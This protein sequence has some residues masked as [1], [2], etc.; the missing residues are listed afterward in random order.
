MTVLFRP[1]GNLSVAPTPRSKSDLALYAYITQRTGIE[2][3]VDD[4]VDY[5]DWMEPAC[6]LQAALRL[7]LETKILPKAELRA[8]VTNPIATVPGMECRDMLIGRQIRTDPMNFMYFDLAWPA[9]C[10]N[11]AN[12]YSEL[13]TFRRHAG[14]KLR[15]ADMPGDAQHGQERIQ[16]FGAPVKST[17]L[18][19]A[20][21]AFRGSSCIVKQVYP[22]KSMPLLIY[23]LP[24]D[25]R[26]AQGKGMFLDD[27]GFHFARFEGD[28]AALLVQESIQMVNETRFFVI[29]G[30][31]VTAAACIEN[32]TPQQN[33]GDLFDLEFEMTRN[34]GEIVKSRKIGRKLWYFAK[35]VVEEIAEEAPQ[36][37]HYV[38]DLAIG[39]DGEPLIVKLN[40]AAQSGLYAIH[41]LSLME[42]IRDASVDAPHR[43]PAYWD[44]E[45]FENRDE[46]ANKGSQDQ[47]FE[48]VIFGD[49]PY[50]E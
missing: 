35:Q 4:S 41:A 22:A 7:G 16:A 19:K 23:D 13:E 21:A 31:V 33:R 28:K 9:A 48:R 29:G 20:M 32:R 24:E 25:F 1:C 14:R 38:L 34:E 3:S 42:A 8:A 30:R 47:A 50:T 15:L 11:L 44:P 18:G 12:H 27:V 40:P 10:N 46:P 26:P 6:M 45:L 5:E 36:M 37:Q 17:G 49:T 2:I 43:E 39:S